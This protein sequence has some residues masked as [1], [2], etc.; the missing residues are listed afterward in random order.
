MNPLERFKVKDNEF[1]PTR[2]GILA[3]ASSG[4]KPQGCFAAEYKNL[5]NRLHVGLG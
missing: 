4:K 5:L 1:I 2:E 3:V